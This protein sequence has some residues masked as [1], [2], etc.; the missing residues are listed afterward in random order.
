[1]K[2]F[3]PARAVSA[4]SRADTPP[5]DPA[6]SIRRATDSPG[7]KQ[8]PDAHEQVSLRYPRPRKKPGIKPEDPMA[9]AG[10][11][12]LLFH[13]A[14]MLKHEEGTRLGADIEE[15]HDMR[16]ATR[17]MRAALDVFG[18]FYKNK[19]VKFHLKGLRATGRALG[20]VRDL[21]VFMEKAQRYLASIPESNRPGLDPL[22]Q[23]W[24]AELALARKK[25]VVYLDSN[26]YQQFKQDFNAFVSTPG[27]GVQPKKAAHPT[28]NLV[29]HVAPVLIHSRLASVRTFETVIANATTVQLHAL[30]IEFKKLRYTLE[31]FREVLGVGAEAVINEIKKVQDHL[32]DLNDADVACRLLRDFIESWQSRQADLPLQ[33]RQNPEPVVAYLGNKHAELHTLMVT[34][35]QAWAQFNRPELLR[36]LALAISVL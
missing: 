29:R 32:G 2:I 31:F 12:T 7:A 1:M 35:P 24:Q 4:T 3:L 17:R 22:M 16:V 19:V 25:M 13:F 6:V 36:E 27:Q 18:P 23:A 34:F 14:L 33:A 9:E 15:L 28:P 26:R 5:A 20:R 8:V 30:R 10:R 21:D 11:K